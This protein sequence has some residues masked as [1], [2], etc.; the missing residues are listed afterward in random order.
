MSE[1]AMT[2]DQVVVIGKGRLIAEMPIDEFTS[3]NSERS[4]RVRSPQLDRLRPALVEAGAAVIDEDGAL[5]VRGLDPEKIG[6]LSLRE[7][8]V[9]SELTPQTAS[10]EEAF[11]ES[12]EGDVE[13]R[14]PR[15]DAAKE[16]S[17]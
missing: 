7:S 5:S 12:T 15:A 13:Y 11:I 14:G 1:M 2:A 16:P 3:R 9:L 17:S 4:V 10:L 6:E 8:I